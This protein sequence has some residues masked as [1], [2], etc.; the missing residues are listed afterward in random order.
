[1]GKAVEIFLDDIGLPFYLL[2]ILWFLSS[3]DGK[4]HRHLFGDIGLAFYLLFIV[5]FLSSDIRRTKPSKSFL[6]TFAH[7]STR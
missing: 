7:L 1:M 2:F 5:W 3:E 6:I 4:S